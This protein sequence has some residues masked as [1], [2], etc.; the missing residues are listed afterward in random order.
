MLSS[1]TSLVPSTA[2]A[3]EGNVSQ[4]A[5]VIDDLGYRRHNGERAVALPGKVSFSFLPGTPYARHLALLAHKRHREVLLHLPME[6]LTGHTLGPGALTRDMSKAQ[7]MRTVHADLDSIPHVAGVSNHM[8]SLLTQDSQAMAWLMEALKARGGLYFLDSRT[9]SETVAEQM[10]ASYGI[11][12]LKR[13][14]FLDNTPQHPEIARQF[15]RLIALSRKR[16][17]AV[18]IGHPHA[19]TLDILE[20][21][22]P[23]LPERGV[24]LVPA[25]KLVNRKRRHQP[26]QLSLSPSPRAARSLKQ[27]PSLTCCA[28]PESPL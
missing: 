17:Y 7:M 10:A 11:P 28:A 6:S 18:G 14:V 9:T 26:W 15:E 27:S 16:G 8:G 24:Q 3:V 19:E 4:I 2:P 23:T 12:H 22:L 20:R 25:S 1:A 13:D 21:L 5:L